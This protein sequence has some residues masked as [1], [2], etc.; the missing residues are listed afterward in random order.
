MPICGSLILPFLLYSTPLS[1]TTA[2]PLGQHTQLR[3][4]QVRAFRF[5]FSALRIIP[6]SPF[7]RPEL[8]VRRLSLACHPIP[9]VEYLTGAL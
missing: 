8:I 1:H 3:T 6:P 5:S 7:P 2:Y 9:R 4:G